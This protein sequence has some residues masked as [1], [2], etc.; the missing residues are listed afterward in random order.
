M[1]CWSMENFKEQ[2]FQDQ[3]ADELL[4]ASQLLR[5]AT[6]AGTANIYVFEK[7]GHKYLVK[8]FA[9]HSLLS[10]W[11][12]GRATIG[13]EWHILRML[14][15]AGIRNVPRAFA[16]LERYTLVMEFV[17]GNQLL[18][19]KHYTADT[20]PPVEFFEQLRQCLHQCHQAGFAHGDFRRANL[21]ICN[22]KTP[23]ILDWATA[24]YCQPNVFSWRFLKRWLHRQQRKADRYSLL[25]IID[26]YYPQLLTDDDR[27]RNQPSWLLRFGRYLRYHLYR[28]G[29]KE[30]LGRAHHCDCHKK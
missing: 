11:F 5:G 27:I 18:S 2:P 21:L 28:H 17:E 1:S 4:A 15:S 26:D 13:N 14:E 9:R 7:D 23:C 12:F 19:A 25:K 3:S 8:S 20:K 24:N 29:L 10:R 22:G 30:W 6:S 16:L